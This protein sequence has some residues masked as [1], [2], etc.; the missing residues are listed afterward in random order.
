M[1]ERVTAIVK[2]S[3]EL[4]EKIRASGFTV[5]GKG[6]AGPVTD[7]DRAVD[8]MLRRQ[9]L[10]LDPCGWL[11]EETADQPSRLTAPRLWIVDPLDGTKEFVAGIPDYCIAVAL[12]E[13]G[14]PVLAVVHNPARDETFVGEKGSG[15][16]KDGRAVGVVEGD[17]ILASRTELTRGEFEAFRTPWAVRPVGSIQYKLALVA[18]GEGSLTLSQGPKWE[19]DVCAGALLVEE[20]GGLATDVFGKELAY[21]RPHPKVRGILAGAPAAHRRGAEVLEAE[22]NFHRMAEFNEPP[23]P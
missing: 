2:E 23:S 8:V 18:A 7:A 3:G 20:A 16:T 22:G 13:A 19:W 11:S 9:L 17:I 12:V 4:M 10:G 5:Q 6:A 15:V 14:R 21:N 1:V